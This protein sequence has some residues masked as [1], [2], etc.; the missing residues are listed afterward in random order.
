[1]KAKYDA[2]QCIIIYEIKDTGKRKCINNL[3]LKNIRTVYTWYTRGAGPRRV[4][5]HLGFGVPVMAEDV[6]KSRS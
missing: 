6:E 4:D 3:K 5:A 2:Y 1:M